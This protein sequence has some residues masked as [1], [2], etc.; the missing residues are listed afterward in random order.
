MI[1]NIDPVSLESW[2]DQVSIYPADV[3]LSLQAQP[4]VTQ[5][6]SYLALRQ[7]DVFQAAL[8]QTA[9]DKLSADISAVETASTST[10]KLAASNTL[11]A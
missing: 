7:R 9:I 3:P 6:R 2:R 10:L 8:T 5:M 11:A 1:G 4:S